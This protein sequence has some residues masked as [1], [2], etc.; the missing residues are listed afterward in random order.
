MKTI[1]SREGFSLIELIVV[2]LLIGVGAGTVIPA[3]GRTLGR[4]R[5]Q[6]AAHV[7]ATDLQ[8]A[9]TTAA[10]RRAP[11]RMSVDTANR[12]VRIVDHITPTTVYSERRFDRTSEY[13]VQRLAASSTTLVFYPTGIAND[14]I[15]FTLTAPSGTR[16]V[17]MSRVGQIRF[18]Q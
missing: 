4:T 8:L 3:V 14:S 16:L 5:L 17:R 15:R 2:L 12:I 6:R 11:I 13:A 18:T 7:V 9:H 1:A 10:R